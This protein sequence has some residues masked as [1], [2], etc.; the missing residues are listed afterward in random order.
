MIKFNP[1]A[2]SIITTI[3]KNS[4]NENAK[5]SLNQS[6][7]IAQTHLKT[8]DSDAVARKIEKT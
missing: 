6:K 3:D 2:T 4:K 7:V 5:F 8:I 1:K